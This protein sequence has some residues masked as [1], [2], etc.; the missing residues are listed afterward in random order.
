MEEVLK[1]MCLRMLLQAVPRIPSVSL[2]SV[3]KCCDQLAI[4]AMRTLPDVEVCVLSVYHQVAGVWEKGLG[5]LV[6]ITE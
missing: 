1:R 5:R 2:G 6:V 4:S 3:G